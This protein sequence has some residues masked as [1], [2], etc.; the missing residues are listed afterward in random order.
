[1]NWIEE[2]EYLLSI[3]TQ[4]EPEPL[5]EVRCHFLYLDHEKNIVES[6]NIMVPLEEKV[7]KRKNY[8]HLFMNNR[9]N[10]R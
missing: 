9:N 5:S 4:L 2:Q 3:D 6:K 1:M 10:I 8:L 7:S